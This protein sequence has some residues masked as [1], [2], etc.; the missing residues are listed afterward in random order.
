SPLATS[1]SCHSCDLPDSLLHRGS[2]A[3][4][5]QVP[6]LLANI[7]PSFTCQNDDGMTSK[8]HL[9]KPPS[10]SIT[11]ASPESSLPQG[12]IH[13]RP[14]SRVLTLPPPSPE[15]EMESSGQ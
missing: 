6:A 2:T 1:L 8:I 11:E 7:L 10:C 13:C 12:C 9:Q 4:Q 5:L 15:S 3:G 14:H